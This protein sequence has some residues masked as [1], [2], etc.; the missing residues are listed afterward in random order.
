LFPVICVR[1]RLDEQIDVELEQLFV[2][3]ASA[4]TASQTDP[5]SRPRAA[6]AM[7]S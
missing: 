6:H 5:S 4:S 2:Q 1:A 3:I 7:R